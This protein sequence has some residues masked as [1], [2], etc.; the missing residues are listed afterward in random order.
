MI[1]H[2][3]DGERV[4]S[5]DTFQTLNPATSE[6]IDEVASGGETEVAAAVAAAKRAFPGWAATPAAQRARLMRR[7]GDL[8]AQNVAEL[9][10]LETQDT[11]QV[12]AQTKKALVPRAADNFYFFS[13]VC[14]RMDG[15]CY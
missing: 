6:V 14:T 15:E 3:I 1:E 9:S 13:E 8:I 5:R 4:G 12:I 2:L 11:G 7:L 10:T